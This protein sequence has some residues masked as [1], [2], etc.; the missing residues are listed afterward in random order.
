[1]ISCE[2]FIAMNE[3]GGWVVGNDES[4]ML[5]KLG[6]DEGGY[7]ARIVKVVVNMD[8]PKMDEVTVEVPATAGKLEAL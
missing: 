1:M 6:D 2:I 3:D 4:E 5:S 7:H 8:P